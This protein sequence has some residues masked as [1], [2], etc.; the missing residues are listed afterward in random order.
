MEFISEGFLG[1]YSKMKILVL[2]CLKKVNFDAFFGFSFFIWYCVQLA[3]FV[4]ILLNPCVLQGHR[5]SGILL[6]AAK[7]NFFQRS[8]P[9]CGP[10]PETTP[11]PHHHSI[12]PRGSH[13]HLPLCS[14]Q[15]LPPDRRAASAPPTTP[16][17]GQT[18]PP[19]RDTGNNR[20]WV[21]SYLSSKPST[22][23]G[24]PP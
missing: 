2:T 12:L 21:C 9:P 7:T 23:V 3:R 1:K 10:G 20:V 18:K 11:H 24:C 4:T 17:T 15:R 13:H 16:R 19:A 22:A 8:R 5:D 14:R 6:K